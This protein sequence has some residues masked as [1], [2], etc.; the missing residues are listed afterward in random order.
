MKIAN[1]QYVKINLLRLAGII[2]IPSGK[3][4]IAEN[5]EIEAEFM[6]ISPGCNQGKIWATQDQLSTGQ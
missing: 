3:R 2:G 4:R 5:G 1:E 6:V